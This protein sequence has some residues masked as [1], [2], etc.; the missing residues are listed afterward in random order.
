MYADNDPRVQEEEQQD[1][2]M[3]IMNKKTRRLYDRMQHGITKKK[4]AVEALV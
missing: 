4:R 1:I 2:A 3:T